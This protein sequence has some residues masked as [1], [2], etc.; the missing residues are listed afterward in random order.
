[1][2]FFSLQCC[3]DVTGERMASELSCQSVIKLC[4]LNMLQVAADEGFLSQRPEAII[5]VL[6]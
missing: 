1:M 4:A 5:R 6:E 2:A 3:N